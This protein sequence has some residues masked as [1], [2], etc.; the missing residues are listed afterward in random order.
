MTDLIYKHYPDKDEGWM[1]DLRSNYVRG[2]HLAQIALDNGLDE[3]LLL[4][5]GERNAG[6]AKNPNILADMLEAIFGALYLDQ[7]WQAIFG[8][9]ERL[10]FASENVGDHTTKDP[11]SALQEL[12]QK[13]LTTT[14]IYTIISEEGKDHEKVFTITAN[15]QGVTIGTGI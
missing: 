12:V 11:K 5:Q 13:H 10:V 14:P 7:G 3:I 9:I 15:I 4:S 2:K 1:T 6:G 8:V